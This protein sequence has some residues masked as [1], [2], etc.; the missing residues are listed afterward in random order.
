MLTYTDKAKTQKRFILPVAIA[1]NKNGDIFVLDSGAA[2]IHVADRSSVTKVK[3]LG[4]Y[5]SPN[6][7]SYGKSTLPK[8]ASDLKITSG[9]SD[10]LIIDDNLFVADQVR[11]EI[12]ILVQCRL[13]SSCQKS[14]LLGILI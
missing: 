7:S 3:I 14:K 5:N 4:K 11:N 8:L 2:C 1:A 9:I 6:T 12:A 10:M 13:A